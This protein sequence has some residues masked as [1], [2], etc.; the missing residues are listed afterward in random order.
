LGSRLVINQLREQIMDRAECSK[1]TAQLAI[2][3]ACQQGCIVQDNGQYRL[4]L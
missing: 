3:E 4:P 1:R 2:S